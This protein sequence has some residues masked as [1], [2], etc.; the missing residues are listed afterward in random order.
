MYLKSEFS[1]P[2]KK[3]KFGHTWNSNL[4]IFMLVDNISTKQTKGFISWDITNKR[5][6]AKIEKNI[7]N[8]NL[9]LSITVSWDVMTPE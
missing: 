8:I 9:E 6:L 2:N 5:V 1:K 4:H 3:I 7:A